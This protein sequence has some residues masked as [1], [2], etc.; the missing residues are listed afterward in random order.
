ML[1]AAITATILLLG[2]S[3]A[4][5]LPQSPTDKYTF[6][7][8]RAASD[9]LSSLPLFKP[10]WMHLEKRTDVSAALSVLNSILPG[11]NISSFTGESINGSAATNYTLAGI[12]LNNTASLN[13]T[14]IDRARS[15]PGIEFIT[16]RG[17]N[18]SFTD[19]FWLRE[20]ARQVISRLPNGT[21]RRTETRYDS[22]IGN[23][24]DSQV[25]AA[26]DGS[27]WIANYTT[28]LAQSCPN[29]TIIM[30]AYS[31]GAAANT[32]ASTRPRFPISRIS[33]AVYWGNPLFQSGRPQNRG[34]AKS[35]LGQEGLLGYRTPRGMQ[36]IVRDYCLTGD[37][38][39]TNWGN[40]LVSI[41][42]FTLRRYDMQSTDAAFL[43]TCFLPIPTLQH[44]APVLCEQHMANANS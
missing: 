38:I 16:T 10:T 5:K 20:M 14:E 2:T 12:P 28:L 31:L 9:E 4:T 6:L 25:K 37:I 36:P 11:L 8:K 3:S 23:D 22:N 19:G 33:G 44:C 1:K 29:T 30:M 39:C 21:S 18:D 24:I 26:L 40:L 15:C 7:A 34:T 43:L 32:V 41:P 35:A 17:A 27:W 13:Q 42:P